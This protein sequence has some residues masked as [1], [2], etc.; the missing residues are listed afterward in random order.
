MVTS[1]LNPD[2]VEDRRPISAINP[3]LYQSQCISLNILYKVV[4]EAKEPKSQDGE[5]QNCIL[6]IE[7][8]DNLSR[9]LEDTFAFLHRK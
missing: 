8:L 4:S 1:S 7:F 2:L 9:L 6:M 3:V 5:E